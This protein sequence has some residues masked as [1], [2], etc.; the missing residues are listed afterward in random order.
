MTTQP[1]ILIACIGNIFQ[2]DDA[3][4]VEVARALAGRKLPVEA[5]VVDF[6]IRGF[7]LTY[8]LMDGYDV[9]VLVDAVPCGDAPGTLYV[10]EPDL[11]ELEAQ[12]ANGSMVDTHGMNP[13]KV[14]SV[15]KTMGAEFK[16]LL[17]VG[18]EPETLGG[19][20]GLMGLSAPVQNAVEKAADLIESLVNKE[21][22]AQYHT[23][24]I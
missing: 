9:T 7:D 8:A 16:R 18:C 12:C 24:N 15:A 14:L 2:G 10:I 3:F 22:S 17:V 20:D 21:L 13:M 5:K 11:N 6:G 4:G 1:R 23:A 19:E